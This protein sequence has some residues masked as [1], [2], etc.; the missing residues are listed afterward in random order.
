MHIVIPTYKRPD[1]QLT[2]HTI[3]PDL[4]KHIT[5]VVRPEEVEHFKKTYRPSKVIATAPHV[6]DFSTTLQFVFDTFATKRFIYMDDDITGLYRRVRF[7][8]DPSTLEKPWAKE[9]LTS[10]E[11]QME[12][13]DAVLSLLDKPYVGS[14]GLRPSY[15][16]PEGRQIKH[17]QANIQFV[18]VDG[19]VVKKIGARWDRLKWG[20]DLD[21]NLQL[22]AAGYDTVQRCDYAYTE[23]GVF[24]GD[25]GSNALLAREKRI[26]TTLAMHDQLAA[27]WPDAFKRLSKPPVTVNP[28]YPKPP[29]RTTRKKHLVKRRKELGIP[30]LEECMT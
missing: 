22:N 23:P 15:L 8:K 12:M 16:P 13:F 18:A 17:A 14:V 10:A 3:H 26:A 6:N 21:F 7:F 30:T 19:R 4:R 28:D 11:D 1:N 29:Y 25:G 20:S 24:N 9:R 2:W 5:F 27:M